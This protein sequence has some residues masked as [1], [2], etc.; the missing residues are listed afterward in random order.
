MRLLSHPPTRMA[1]SR[2]KH[3]AH[4]QKVKELEAA[5]TQSTTLVQP[6]SME[7]P[8]TEKLLE[9]IKVRKTKSALIQGEGR[10][11][12]MEID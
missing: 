12:A 9:R 2:E 8:K 10:T 5:K 3:R 7:S 4:R 1:I 6:I 11:M